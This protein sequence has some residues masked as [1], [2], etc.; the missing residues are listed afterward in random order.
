MIDN[1][2]QVTRPVV[3]ER[4]PSQREVKD[5]K[6]EV[7]RLGDS[8]IDSESREGLPL[9]ISAGDHGPQHETGR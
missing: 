6:L 4:R 8:L 9:F 3:T 1:E 5:L 7:Q 2:Q